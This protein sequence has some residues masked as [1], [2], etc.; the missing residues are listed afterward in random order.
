[1]VWFLLGLAPLVIF[2]G[3]LHPAH[4]SIRQD[5]ARYWIAFI[6][7]MLM[8]AVATIA[9]TARWLLRLG[10]TAR[11]PAVVRRSVATVA[12]LALLAWPVTAYGR[13]LSHNEQFAPAGGNAMEML[14][15]Y[16]GKE[17]PKPPQQLA[18]VWANNYTKRLLQ[19]YARG[20]FGGPRWHAYVRVLDVN[21][22]PRPG[23]FVVTVNHDTCVFCVSGMRQWT[24]GRSALTADWHVA[25]SAP[26]GNVVVYRVS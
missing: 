19:F 13:W 7:P 21:A 4:P 24:L 1:M 18:T 10:Q 12:A 25:W 6:V 20:P 16:L 26:K 14:R 17:L 9:E 2:G 8:A 5:I 11:L 15:G 3:V 22:P 23:D